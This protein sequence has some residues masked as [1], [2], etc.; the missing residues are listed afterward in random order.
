MSDNGLAPNR[1]Q[2]SIWTN[3]SLVN[4]RIHTSLGL[5][6]LRRKHMQTHVYVDWLY[7]MVC[8]FYRCY[9]VTMKLLSTS[10][11]ITSA[12]GCNQS[13][14]NKLWFRCMYWTDDVIWRHSSE[15]L[16]FKKTPSYWNRDSYYKLETVDRPS[17]VYNR[18]SNT[19]KTT[20]FSDKR[21][22]INNCSGNVLL[23]NA[24]KLLPKLI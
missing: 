2:A 18:V 19:H 16:F 5:N 24:T 12:C 21:P 13:V 11:T 23:P 8:N 20:S 10:Q 17:Y 9:I 6:W 1:R 4:R 22:M 14:C 15:S 3:D 7:I